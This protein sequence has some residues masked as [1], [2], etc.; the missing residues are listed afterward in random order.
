MKTYVNMDPLSTKFLKIRK[1]FICRKLSHIWKKCI[2][3]L[4]DL[5][6]NLKL[7]VKRQ[8]Q[9]F[10][11]NYPEISHLDYCLYIYINTNW[12][13]LFLTNSIMIGEFMSITQKKSWLELIW[14]FLNLVLHMSYLSEVMKFG[15]KC[16]TN[17]LRNRSK[18]NTFRI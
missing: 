17:S 13:N 6:E 7:F 15:S 5:F 4:K 3:E 10:K 9:K 11:K 8:G 1:R 14:I 12:K 18:N 2:I 16:Q